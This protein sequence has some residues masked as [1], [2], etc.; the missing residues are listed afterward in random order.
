MVGGVVINVRL[1]AGLVIQVRD[2]PFI[3]SVSHLIRPCLLA[4][5][6][7]EEVLHKDMRYPLF[8]LKNVQ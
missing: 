7:S 2:T 6:A 5:L 1:E 4:R 3:G 8:Y